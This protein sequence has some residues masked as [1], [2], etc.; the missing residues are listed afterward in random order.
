VKAP[1][2]PNPALEG[3]LR[4][5]LWRIAW[6]AITTQL[7]VFL[8]NFVDYQWVALLGEEAAAGQGAAWTTFWMLASLGQVF[9]TGVAAVVA[10]RVGEREGEAARFAGS[11]GI[12]GAVLAGFVV[13]ALGLFA[14]P[15]LV[16]WYALSPEASGHAGDYLRTVCLGAPAFFFFWGV[17]G[18]FKG[19]GD[20][21][22][23]LRAV[24][25]TLALNM[26][27]D[28][29]LIHG[30]GLEVT[31]AALATVIAF[32]LTALLLARNATAR[33]WTDWLAPGL[34]A[35]LIG[36]MIRIGLP[37]SMHGIIFSGVYVFI[38]RETSREGGDAATAALSLGLR[39]EGVAYMTA[40]GFA[41]AAAT[42]VGQN[43]GAKQIPRAHAS[44]WLSVRLAV[45]VTGA[46]GLLMLVAPLAVVE[47]MS[48]SG[49]AAL[50]AA[51]YFKIAAVAVVFM[52]IEIVLEGAFSG[53]RHDAGDLP[54]P[55]VHGAAR[56]GGDA[57]RAD[58]RVGGARHL[59][60]AVADQRDARP[61]VRLLVRKKPLDNRRRV[62]TVPPWHGCKGRFHRGLWRAGADSGSALYRS[63]M[64][65]SAGATFLARISWPSSL[66]CRRS[67][68]KYSFFPAISSMKNGT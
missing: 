17:E 48:P 59:L 40:V 13:G 53:G 60:G 6:P 58:A 43:L 35:R 16:S 18:N 30:A 26:V 42:L 52:S 47:A 36:R 46:W 8:N 4:P 28:P 15:R 55:A 10:R 20:T 39:V 23:P 11:Q 32:L 27:L 2:P 19:R 54:G 37:V 45:Q 50:Y 1:G 22:R 31:G 21:R 62:G 65:F 51:D 5:A 64:L 41:T 61:A 3:P 24:A 33:G 7:L 25:I 57:G 9:S 67:S 34:A 56:A 29:L 63:R 49:E 44:A 14:A 12:R 38:M 68:R 66:G